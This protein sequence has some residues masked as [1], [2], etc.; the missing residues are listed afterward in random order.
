M[1]VTY[2]ASYIIKSYKKICF[3]ALKGGFKYDYMVYNGRIEL[4]ITNYHNK[5][6]KKKMEKN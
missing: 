4:I 5:K 2:G 1:K 3:C 6:K